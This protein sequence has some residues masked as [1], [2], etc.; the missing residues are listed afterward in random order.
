M[1]VKRNKQT[2]KIQGEKKKRQELYLETNSKSQWKRYS[3]HRSIM[4]DLIMHIT[5]IQGEWRE[6]SNIV[7]TAALLPA[8]LPA[9]RKGG[10][11]EE[12]PTPSWYL[13]YFCHFTCS[14]NYHYRKTRKQMAKKE[15]TT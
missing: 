5:Y 1:G 6:M 15:I 7:Y 13:F 14:T 10:R 4:K 2:E 11:I 9:W 12:V 8:C 3:S